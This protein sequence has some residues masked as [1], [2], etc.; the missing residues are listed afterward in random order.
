LNLMKKVKVSKA[1]KDKASSALNKQFMLSA[2]D[3]IAAKVVELRK[4]NYGRM[5]YGNLSK[6]KMEGRKIYPKLL[7]RT[8]NNHVKI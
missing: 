1:A 3:V 7:R 5:P 8:V 6:M 2:I 4:R